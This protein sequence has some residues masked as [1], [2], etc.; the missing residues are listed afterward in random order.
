MIQA[1]AVSAIS[2]LLCKVVSWSFSDRMPHCGQSKKPT[3]NRESGRVKSQMP[4]KFESNF[5]EIRT[6]NFFPNCTQKSASLQ[7]IFQRWNGNGNSFVR[8]GQNHVVAETRSGVRFCSGNLTAPCVGVLN[9]LVTVI[10]VSSGCVGTT[11]LYGDVMYEWRWKM[12]CKYY[13]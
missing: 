4:K 12:M 10:N 6:V 7:S 13:V 9:D 5:L 3:A 11:C 8:Q 1:V 2:T